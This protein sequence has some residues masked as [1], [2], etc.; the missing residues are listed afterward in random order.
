M[1]QYVISA[2]VTT[3]YTL[4]AGDTLTVL[5]GGNAVNVVVDSGGLE[6]VSSGGASSDTTVRFGGIAALH[7]GE[8]FATVVSALGQLQISGGT[9]SG[10][11]LRLGGVDDVFAGGSAVSTTIFDSSV[12]IAFSGGTVAGTQVQGGGTLIAVPGATVQPPTIAA[13]GAE[14]TSGFVV[15]LASGGVSAVSAG[16]TVSGL[17][18]QAGRPGFVLPGGNFVDGVIAT[19]AELDVEADGTA[20]GVILAP[21]GALGV[22]SGGATASTTVLSG[23]LE[24][25]FAG[26]FVSSASA[27]SGG[28]IY[29]DG[30]KGN[31]LLVS[32]SGSELL[33]GPGGTAS[34]TQVEDF[35]FVQVQ[36]GGQAAETIL[37]DGG[38][39]IISNGGA[40]V[41]TYFES[42]ASGFVL[43]GGLL[44]SFLVYSGASVVLSA[45]SSLYATVNSGA[46]QIVDSG[47][48]ANGSEIDGNQIVNS[49]GFSEAV[50]VVSAGNLFVNSGGSA[51]DVLV[52][53]NGY[54]EVRSGGAV[55]GVVISG[56]GLVIADA[57]GNLSG[58]V[59]FADVT[60][61]YVTSNAT[62][63]TNVNDF[64]TGDLLVAAGL[65][66]VSAGSAVLGGSDL[67]TISQGA[68]SFTVQFDGTVTGET[69]AW[70]ADSSAG[71]D[72]YIVPTVTSVTAAN[73]PVNYPTISNT[74]VFDVGSGGQ[75]NNARLLSGGAINV[76][77]GGIAAASFVDGGTQTVFSGGTALAAYL[78]AGSAEI[79]SSGG[80]TS[81]GEVFKGSTEEILAGGSGYD[82]MLGQAYGDGGQLSAGSGV[83]LNDTQVYGGGVLTVAS[84]AAVSATV[85]YAGG[86]LVIGS[87][88]VASGATLEGGTVLIASGGTLADPVV[89]AGVLFV[90]AGATLVNPVTSGGEI[91]LLA[92][93]ILSGT[94]ASGTNVIS[95]GVLLFQNGNLTSQ[96]AEIDG[97]TVPYQG[98]PLIVLSAGVTNETRVN[99]G[100]LEE[101][102]GGVA[103]GSELGGGGTQTVAAG[104]TAVATD[105]G[106]GGV[107]I[108][109]PGGG[110]SGSVYFTGS[111]AELITSNSSAGTVLSG[112]NNTSL[113]DAASLHFVSNGSGLAGAGDI[114]TVTEG[115]SSFTAQFD[116]GV[117]SATFGWS[118]D[119]AGGTLIRF[120]YNRMVVSGA[121][122]SAVSATVLAGDQLI[123]LS[124]GI[125][126]ATI[127]DS[128]GVVYVSAGGSAVA[129]LLNQYASQYVSSG[130]A[131]YGTTLSF[132]TSQYV[133]SGAM[134]SGTIFKGG[135]QVV[136]GGAVVSGDQITAYGVELVSSGGS[137]V[138]A[139]VTGQGTLNVQSGGAATGTQVG[140]LGDEVVQSGG[141]ALGGSVTYGGNFYVSGGGSAVSVTLYAGDNFIVSSG[142]VALD[143]QLGSGA[144]ATVNPGAI[145]RGTVVL[146]GGTQTVEP[147]AVTSGT[148][149]RSAGLAV[150]SGSATYVLG[151]PEI[152]AGIAE[153]TQI[154]S[155][156]EVIVRFGGVA[157]DTQIASGGVLVVSKGGVAYNPDIAS[158]G[159]VVVLAGGAVSGTVTGGGQVISSGVA[160]I[161]IGSGV[162]SQGNGLTGLSIINQQTDYVLSGGTTTGT[163]IYGGGVEF[164]DAG[165][166]ASDTV[167]NSAVVPGGTPNITPGY[168]YVGDGG[169]AIGS[170][171]KYL[172][173]LAVASGGSI[174]NVLDQAGEG[175]YYLSL[176]GTAVGTTV[177]NGD[178]YVLSG[179]SMS[180]TLVEGNGQGIVVFAGGSITDTTATNYGQIEAGGVISN[181]VIDGGFVEVNATDVA[182]YLNFEGTGGTLLLDYSAPDTV[183]SGFVPG[184]TIGLYGYYT[185]ADVTATLGS[186]NVLTASAGGKTYTVNL[187]PNADYSHDTI[188][189]SSIDYPNI[190]GVIYAQIY[191]AI[192]L[193]AMCFA[194]GT[195]IRTPS[196]EVAVEDLRIG[197]AV[198][199]QG[200]GVLPVKWIGWRG[201]DGRFIAGNHL[202]LPVR[203]RR[204]ALGQDMPA[205][206]LVV[207][208]GH[209]IWVD[210]ALVPAWR[211][212]N[213]VSVTQGA[214]VE[215]IEY[216]HI[217]LDAHAVILAEGCPA[218]SFLEE[219]NRHQFQNAAQY[220]ALYPETA[221]PVRRLPRLE[222]G[223]RLLAL[224]RRVAARAGLRQVPPIRPGRLRGFLDDTGALG[225]IA[226]WAQDEANPEAPVTLDVWVG[227]TFLGRVLANAYRA[228]LRAAGLGSGCHG[229]SMPHP[230]GVAGRVEVRRS[231]D[232]V[233][234][235]LSAAALRRV[236]G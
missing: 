218:E 78:V 207:S 144:G 69:F 14:V 43:S 150:L 151:V 79:V 18:I 112:F 96:G 91:V 40:A 24:Q 170:D 62:G 183:I 93:G 111:G 180:D 36:S 188:S 74:D 65:A 167:I 94:V 200:G 107:E 99:N 208:P 2:G 44:S 38:E 134:V 104:A 6:I 71:T 75:V 136:E 230:G 123:A 17:T 108:V 201:Y 213:G 80:V 166:V 164:I 143:T 63:L 33:I 206:D 137:V 172:A 171:E 225:C 7:G 70:S 116:P 28:Q 163:Q 11:V 178:V 52:V 4:G 3:G 95:T 232:Q 173:V 21:G 56:G 12:E 196:G 126:S 181:T 174:S 165:A 53:S 161:A 182:G 5:S 135:T 64:Q 22:F 109:A 147:G 133:L 83:A 77:S 30:G 159:A 235:G 220:A 223:P 119:G 154:A 231:A 9:G 197:D 27:I 61:E 45:G 118:A 179:A 35:G 158:G 117:G 222:D 212:I 37:R 25:V 41:V 97:L 185:L 202:M 86:T 102:L 76:F 210:G 50:A 221:A 20:S 90:S 103:S 84:G 149:V 203:I 113:L 34:N 227:G 160:V 120:L 66:F 85:V 101:V 152:S 105:I 199:T 153:D 195:R 191:T 187:D 51:G 224:Q 31:E 141:S 132:N 122:N 190:N 145:Y 177:D 121:G 148:Q 60:G 219:D 57:G 32:N 49:G 192:T 156:G 72:I 189:L 142:G 54:L 92:G 59:T 233:P 130:G 215:R 193:E 204:H 10:T 214:A 46:T 39:L 115:G 87:G 209:G 47:G 138:S 67:L 155:G 55:S 88:V 186:Q 175:F 176:G 100:G 114:L 229:F 73:S 68:A 157:S 110:L 139:F 205:R 184:D 82:V 228:D 216:F 140:F 81:S 127:V 106:A 19:G 26:G 168:E 131:A 234:L 23:G 58:G 146:S 13:G 226:G 125:A 89:S 211:L 15:L 162:I 98:S 48:V 236:I 194:R 198:V 128:G 124:G 217:E 16:T 169:T 29:L 42:G 129:S 8:A 1:T